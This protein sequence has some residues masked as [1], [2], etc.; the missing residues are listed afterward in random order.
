MSPDGVHTLISEDKIERLKQ[1]TATLRTSGSY[2]AEIRGSTFDKQI[3]EGFKN[4]EA[5]RLRGQ[6]IRLNMFQESWI[7]AIKAGEYQRFELYDLD[8]DPSQRTNVGK[9]NRVVFH[10]L[11]RQLLEL[12]ASVMADAPDWSRIAP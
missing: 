4:K 11:R 7:P 8:A 10:R 5:E 6:F 9:Q 2:E 1:I 12:N 3:F